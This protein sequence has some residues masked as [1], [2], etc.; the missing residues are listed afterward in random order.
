[1]FLVNC[2]QDCGIPREIEQHCLKIKIIFK[3]NIL[4]LNIKVHF[5]EFNEVQYVN[6]FG[7]L[8]KTFANVTGKHAE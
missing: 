8:T 1:M 6:L 3:V 5:L 7:F 4:L 2:G